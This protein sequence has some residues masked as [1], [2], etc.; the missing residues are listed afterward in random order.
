MVFVVVDF[1]LYLSLIAAFSSLQY[2]VIHM[3]SQEAKKILHEIIA[4]VLESIIALILALC[5]FYLT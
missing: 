4:L 1:V 2:E 5:A 3:S